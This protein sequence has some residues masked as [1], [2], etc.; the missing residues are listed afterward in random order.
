MLLGL[1]GEQQE[2]KEEEEE[3]KVVICPICCHTSKKVAA[4]PQKVAEPANGLSLSDLLLL[5]HTAAHS[6]LCLF[7]CPFGHNYQLGHNPIWFSLLAS[8]TCNEEP[9]WP[10]R[11]HKETAYIDN[12]WWEFAG[13]PCHPHMCMGGITWWWQQW[14]RRGGGCFVQS[15]NNSQCVCGCFLWR[16]TT[17]LKIWWLSWKVIPWVHIIMGGI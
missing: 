5:L 16:E 12:T 8:Q 3:A 2:E 9:V 11:A 1:Q 13:K 17:P 7:A 6:Y 10:K 15:I 14:W 4:M